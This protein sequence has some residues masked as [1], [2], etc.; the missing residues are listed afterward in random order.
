M[1]GSAS[2]TL[3]LFMK[4]CGDKQLQNVLVVTT[5][6]NGVPERIGSAREE[7]LRTNYFQPLLSN[8]AKMVRHDGTR[9][10]REIVEEFLREKVSEPPVILQIQLQM[11][12]ER[13]RLVETDAG[14]EVASSIRQKIQKNK[15][16]MKEMENIK[17]G[18]S[19]TSR[20]RR[21]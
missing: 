13:R 6:W 3:K 8:G 9:N 21:Y 19:L 20:A 4:I 12:K 1:T 14:V 17:G 2:L 10:P 7:E 11:V 16:E 5:G 18:H 15:S